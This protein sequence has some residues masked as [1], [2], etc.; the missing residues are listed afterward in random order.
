MKIVKLN[1][2]FKINKYHGFEVGVKF[3]CWDR[4]A[5]NFEKVVADR[6]GDQ[7]WGWKWNPDKKVK[8]NWAGAFGERRKGE[9]A[10][11]WIYIRRESMLSLVLLSLEHQKD[12]L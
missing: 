7:S 8:E 10:P 12:A 3:D 1:R 5:L 4:T 11:Y 9:A 2:N 6:L